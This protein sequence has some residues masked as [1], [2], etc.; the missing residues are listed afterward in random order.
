MRLKEI[1]SL[2]TSY[3]Q[4]FIITYGDKQGD[5]FEIA[6]KK[7]SK[8]TTQEYLN[9]EVVKIHA[10]TYEGKIVLRVAEPK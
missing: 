5:V 3:G 2:E 4:E 10:T 8:D 1:L 9:W 7:G 6:N